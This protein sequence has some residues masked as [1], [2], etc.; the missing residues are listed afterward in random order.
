MRRERRQEGRDRR[1]RRTRGDLTAEVRGSDW[2]G[3]ET[4][5]TDDKI[6]SRVTA[7]FVVPRASLFS[8]GRRGQREA[9]SEGEGPDLIR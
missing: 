2:V 7:L 6:A 3:R 8:K 1:D 5:T 9:Q 4:Y